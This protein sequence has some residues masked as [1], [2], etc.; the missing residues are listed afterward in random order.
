MV[1][2]TKSRHIRPNA[3]LDDE[4]TVVLRGGSLDTALLRKDAERNFE[5]YGV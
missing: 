5:I 3:E 1:S 4:T 2:M